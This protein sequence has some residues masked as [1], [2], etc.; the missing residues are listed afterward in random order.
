MTQSWHY[1]INAIN[2]LM[3]LFDKDFKEAIINFL[4]KGNTFETK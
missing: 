1:L 2:Y 3:E 4:S